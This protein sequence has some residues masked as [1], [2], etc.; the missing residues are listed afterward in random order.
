MLHCREQRRVVPRDPWLVCGAKRRIV[1]RGSSSRSVFFTQAF[2]EVVRQRALKAQHII[3]LNFV[4]ADA[5]LPSSSASL[6]PLLE[7]V[8]T[9]HVL[10]T[11]GFV[12]ITLLACTSPEQWP[13]GSQT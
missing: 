2:H 3:V 11:K 12:S 5:S 10:L 4:P 7:S 1:S 9:F 8:T 13:R 6:F